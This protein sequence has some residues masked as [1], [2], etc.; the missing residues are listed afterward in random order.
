MDI[1]AAVRVVAVAVEAVS[2]M[3]TGVRAEGVAPD[4]SR[5]GEAAAWEA[6]AVVEL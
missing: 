5:V 3:V 1:V 6:A 4:V 2:E